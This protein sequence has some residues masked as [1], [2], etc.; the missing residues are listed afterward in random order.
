MLGQNVRRETHLQRVFVVRVVG[1]GQAFFQGKATAE[2]AGG[3]V[4]VFIGGEARIIF[5]VEVVIEVRA[6]DLHFH[7]FG[8]FGYVFLGSLFLLLSAACGEQA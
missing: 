5:V 1:R 6:G 8:P 7:D 4:S 2:I 3:D